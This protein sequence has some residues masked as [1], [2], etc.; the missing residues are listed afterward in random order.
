MKQSKN[1]RRPLQ[2]MQIVYVH[3]DG[4]KHAQTYERAVYVTESVRLERT[5][6]KIRN[7]AKF[8]TI[9]DAQCNAILTS[10]QKLV[11]AEKRNFRRKADRTQT[12]VCIDPHYTKRN[13]RRR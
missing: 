11:E 8:D 1:H 13:R 6:R 12:V 9:Q 5:K 2:S 7:R 4:S 3:A 10:D